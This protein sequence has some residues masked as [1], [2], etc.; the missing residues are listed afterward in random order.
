LALIIYRKSTKEVRIMSWDNLIVFI[1]AF[2]VGFLLTD[3]CRG[4]ETIEKIGECPS[5]W[6]TSGKYCVP[7][8]YA[9]Y[10][11]EKKGECPVGFTTAG[12][13]CVKTGK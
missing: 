1:L 6:S 7:G 3:K 9:K 12:K 10:V 2:T 5:G 8:K 4:A 13:Y 11:I